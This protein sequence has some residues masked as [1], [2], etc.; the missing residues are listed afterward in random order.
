MAQL[1]QPFFV[2]FGA[3]GMVAHPNRW[4]A[5]PGE[6]VLAQNVTLEND[7][8][9]KEPAATY[10]DPQ[11]LDTLVFNVAWTPASGTDPSLIL[12]VWYDA[13]PTTAIIQDRTI[14]Q[15]AA[16]AVTSPWTQS[17]FGAA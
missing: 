8:V 2:P 3:S 11:G 7:L 16:G 15:G 12:A 13:L 5:T 9:N 4:R 14:L 10:Y 17:I 1:G 6:M